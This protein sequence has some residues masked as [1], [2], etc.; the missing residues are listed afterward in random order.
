MLAKPLGVSADAVGLVQHDELPRQAWR[1]SPQIFVVKHR[2]AIFLGIGDPDDRVDAGEQLVHARA[3]FTC[4]RVDI[5]QIED[6]DV[7]ERAVAVISYLADLEPSEERSGLRA[8]ALGDPGD[9]RPGR[10]ATR[11]RRADVGT[12]E[13]IEKARFPDTRATHEREDVRGSL[14]AKPLPRISQDAATA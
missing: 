3:V 1:P 12:R 8:R 9:G 10:G 6:R 5:R 11:A 14:E 7:G 4:G 13:R 2:V